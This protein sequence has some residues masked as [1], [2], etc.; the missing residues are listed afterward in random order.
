MANALVKQM[1]KG[2]KQVA[3]EFQSEGACAVFVAGTFNG[4]DPARDRL[5][6]VGFD[7]RFRAALKLPKGRHEYKFVVDDVWCPDPLN[8]ETVAN[9]QGTMN[10]VLIV[11]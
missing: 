7:G 11:D 9:D 3:L 5:Q 2:T 1:R 6:R 8:P 10:S 4:W